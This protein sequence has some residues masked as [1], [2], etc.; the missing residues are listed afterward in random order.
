MKAFS[1]NL[2][3]SEVS[4]MDYGLTGATWFWLLL[5]MPLLV[6]ISL[7]SYLKERRN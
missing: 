4:Q 3:S 2:L 5:P 1:Q 6:I 7:I